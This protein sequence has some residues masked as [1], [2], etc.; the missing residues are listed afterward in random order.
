[1]SDKTEDTHGRAE[2]ELLLPW[3]VT[4]RLNGQETAR[5]EAFLAAHPDLQRQLAL[6]R[7]EQTEA[8]RA[9]E[10]LG[11]PSPALLDRAMRSLAGDPHGSLSLRATWDRIAEFFAAPTPA[12]LR[13][14]AAIAGLVFLFQAAVIGTL[15][16]AR[17]S[18][19]YETAGSKALPTAGP[20]LLVGF[21]DG[22]TASA[23]TALLS[24]LDAQVIEGPKPGGIYRLRLTKTPATNTA[25]QEIVRRLTARPDVVK[26]VLLGTD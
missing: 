15:I 23:V 20:T 2:I 26:I 18:S 9:N 12:G 5:V 17:S 22:A 1:M 10:A 25:L 13:W 21:A 3:Y 4:G 19:L 14:A 7:E 11:Q 24:E 8:A 16:L 6:V